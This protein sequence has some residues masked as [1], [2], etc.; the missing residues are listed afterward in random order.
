MLH[1]PTTGDDVRYSHIRSNPVVLTLA[2]ASIGIAGAMNTATVS[3]MIVSSVL[4]VC[5]VYGI[6]TAARELSKPRL[7]QLSIGLWLAFIAI[8]GVHAVG[9]ETFAS[10]LSAPFVAF[11]SMAWGVTWATLI[12]ASAGTSF[13][14]FR[15]YAAGS[16]VAQ[17]EDNVIDGEYDF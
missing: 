3:E 12:G 9:L 8:A 2:L 17:P 6:A 1:P 11:T 4:V 16:Y 13:L 15:E 10:T 7:A 14:A 5:G